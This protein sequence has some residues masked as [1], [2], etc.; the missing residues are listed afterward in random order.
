VSKLAH[1]LVAAFVLS[2]T[3]L[4]IGCGGGSG[5]GSDA[6]P[7]SMNVQDSGNPDV[8]KPHHDGGKDSAPPPNDS[9]KDTGPGCPTFPAF[10][11]D[12]V[13]ND[14]KSNNAPLPIPSCW[15][16][17]AKPVDPQTPTEFKSLIK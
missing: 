3:A 15:G 5:N 10:V 14:T 17:P 11:I 6:S 12:M 8:V 9:G 2:G 16:T 4:A 7:D 1:A 13:Q